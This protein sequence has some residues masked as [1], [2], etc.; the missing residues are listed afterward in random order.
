M[1]WKYY[2]DKKKRLSERNSKQ[3]LSILGMS[4][5]KRMDKGQDNQEEVAA[6]SIDSR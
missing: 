6:P 3:I 2:T 1:I 4:L 5:E